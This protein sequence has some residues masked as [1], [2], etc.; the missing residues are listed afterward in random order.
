MSRLIAL[1]LAALFVFSVSAKAGGLDSKKAMYVGGTVTSIKERSEGTSST[2]DEKVF[3]FT[4][5]DGNK[6]AKLTVPYDR[7]NDLEYAQKAGR[8]VEWAIAFT[9]CALLSK[10]R[11][12]FRTTGS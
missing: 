10:K 7:V 12:H 8:R 5:K 4:Y 1:G 3:V 11:N 2:N 6:E 9:P